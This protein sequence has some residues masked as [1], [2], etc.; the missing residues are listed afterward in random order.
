MAT[1]MLR[2]VTTSIRGKKSGQLTGVIGAFA[3]IFIASCFI[4]PN[5]LT[6]YNLTIMARDLAFIGIVAIA[7]GLLLLLGD[8]DVS[9]GA[10]AGLCAVVT[11]KL[12]VD[13]TMNP[14]LAMAVGLAA[15]ALLGCINGLLITAFNLNSLV[16]TIGTQTAFTGLNLLV[17]RGRTI[18]GLPEKVT[19]LGAGSLFEI[20]MPV[21][22]LVGV[23][24]IA[25][26]IATK[27]VLGRQLYAIGNSHE[28]ARIVGIKE[29]KV[30]VIAYSLAGVF[31][32][33]AGILMGFRLLSA[34][35]AI[36]Q[37]WV[38]P[39][40]AA[41]V[42]GGIATTGGIGSIAGALFGG[43][44]MGVIGNIIVL[45]GVDVYWQQVFNGVIVVLAI[46]LDS[47]SRRFGRRK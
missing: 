23:F 42:I 47:L 33:L 37:T 46:T 11:A 12:L 31:A 34:Q 26:F 18:T 24:A 30:R 15:G 8:I 32:G 43:A 1:S 14:V 22:F 20:P 6:G 28:A 5:F 45:G 35:T 2:R 16:L 40:I 9:I 25:L 36:G 4:S 44:I 17:T 10:I 27:T 21:Y 39:S 29:Q 19:F 3:L 38:L 13:Y 7:Q 41:P